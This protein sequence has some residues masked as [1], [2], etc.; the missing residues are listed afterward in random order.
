MQA[1]GAWR[2][3]LKNRGNPTLSLA[4]SEGCQGE[5]NALFVVHSSSNYSSSPYTS[6][7]NDNNK[8]NIYQELIRP[9]AKH[10][11]CILIFNPHNN[12]MRKLL[13]V[14]SFSKSLNKFPNEKTKAWKGQPAP[15][16]SWFLHTRTV[17]LTTA[18]RNSL[19]GGAANLMCMEAI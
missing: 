14:S 7:I 19:G 2:S 16:Q 4:S 12:P 9:H 3:S 1:P 13:L 15:W 17:Y 10:F 11:S 5:R 6:I 18:L 8:K